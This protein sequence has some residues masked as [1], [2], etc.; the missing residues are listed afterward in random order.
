MLELPPSCLF[1]DSSF[2]LYSLHSDTYCKF[3]CIY[4]LKKVKIAICVDNAWYMYF[5]IVKQLALA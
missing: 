1:L 3:N 4:L 5:I 2:H